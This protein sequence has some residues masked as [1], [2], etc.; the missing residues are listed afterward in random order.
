[1]KFNSIVAA[2]DIISISEKADTAFR[3]R[4]VVPV[5]NV[6][7]QSHTAHQPVRTDLS[8]VS[9]NIRS[10]IVTLIEQ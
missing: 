9:V 2:S 5:R 3:S 7:H 4:G 8:R 6:V 10:Q 1:M